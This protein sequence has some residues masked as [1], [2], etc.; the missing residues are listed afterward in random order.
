MNI[1]ELA[2]L[3][4]WVLSALILF[5]G[6]SVMVRGDTSGLAIILIGVASASGGSF[7]TAK[8]PISNAKINET[9]E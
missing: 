9:K 1:K 3:S 5:A 7:C 2:K 4:I 8:R 6:L